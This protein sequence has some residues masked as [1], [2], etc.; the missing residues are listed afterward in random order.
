[1]IA[2][3]RYAARCV[4]FVLVV[5]RIAVLAAQSAAKETGNRPRGSAGISRGGAPWLVLAEYQRYKALGE[6]AIAQL[7]DDELSAAGPG[8]GNSTAALVWHLAGNLESRF[9]D[10][11]TSDG[12][13]P[14]RDRDDEFAR[15][16]VTREALIARW[17]AGWRVLL[18]ALADLKDGDVDRTVTIRGHALR[19][20][21]ALLRSLAHA[22]YHVGRIVYLAKA[23]R[24]GDWRCL[25]IPPGQSRA[26]NERRPDERAATHAAALGRLAADDGLKR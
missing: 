13:K 22:S 16:A 25:S 8:G 15:R 14:W 26:Y 4:N 2:L 24:G 3:D 23:F 19:V 10:F 12:E 5:P 20:E 6:A 18:S 21:E 17:D 9:T 1:M 7:R 11:L